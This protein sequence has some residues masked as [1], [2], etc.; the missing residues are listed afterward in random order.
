MKCFYKSLKMFLKNKNMFLTIRLTSEKNK[1]KWVKNKNV[2]AQKKNKTFLKKNQC[3]GNRSINSRSYL[4]L[5]LC[6]ILPDSC[7]HTKFHP[8]RTKEIKIKKIGYRLAFV[9]WSS[10]SKNSCIHFKLILFGF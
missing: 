4:K 6:C 3:S 7:P 8:N 2:E 9:G 10:Q 5:I 1:N